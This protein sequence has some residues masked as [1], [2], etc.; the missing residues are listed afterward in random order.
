MHRKAIKQIGKRRVM[1]PTRQ[2][3]LSFLLVILIGAV[4]LSMPM[5]NRDDPLS[6]MDHLFVAT[7]VTCVT[8][9][10]PISI[11]EQ[12]T[13]WGQLVILV[14]IQI[15]GLGF[16]TFLYLL[17]SKI[18]KK[19]ALRQKIVL[20]EMLNQPSISDSS[21]MVRRILS[22]TFTCQGVGAALLMLVFVPRYGALRGS[23]YS[24]FHAISSFTNAGIDLFGTTSL[25]SYQDHSLMLLITAGLV[26]LGS[27]GFI[28]WFDVVHCFWKQRSSAYAFSY[29]RFF[30]RLSLHSK[31]VIIMSIFLTLSATL[32]VF[33]A[34]RTN[35]QTIGN[36]SIL[37]QLQN[38]FFLSVSS[39][40]A[41][42][43]TFP[44]AGL[45]MGTKLI[46]WVYMFIGGSPASTAG[47]IK[48]TTFMIT[49]LMVY[50]I[51]KGKREVQLFGRRIPRRLM[52]RSFA[53]ISMAIVVI[54]TALIIVSFSEQMPFFDVAV[55]VVSAFTT[56]GFSH[57]VTPFLSS[58]G[59]IVIL[60]LMFIGR[61]GPITMLISFVNKSHRQKEKKEIGY[62][63]GELL[64]G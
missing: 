28:V 27:L 52:I 44:I 64:L 42:F 40:T 5:A 18:Q 63:D 21:L 9:L 48:T 26:M 41:G 3:I 46:L 49:V 37:G 39:R 17:L 32:I 30:L 55:E 35:P 38:S 62:P 60:I 2:I 7:S 16:L 51:Y 6:L 10:L 58:L 59:S 45:Q 56:V 11:V 61:I 1:S 23:Y 14:L 33:F 47:G 36:L 15:G 13:I 22:Y 34:E 8:G 57:Q 4:L 24:I 54:F 29:R 50:N 20:Q 53:I 12:Y 43:T 31:I 25:A 19:L